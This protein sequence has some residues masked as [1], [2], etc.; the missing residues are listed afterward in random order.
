MLV[1]KYGDCQL[2]KE[3]MK[4]GMLPIDVRTTVAP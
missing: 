1:R 2:I 3:P 4:H